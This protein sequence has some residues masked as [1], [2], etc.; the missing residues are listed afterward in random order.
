MRFGSLFLAG[1]AAH[2]VPPTGAKGLNLAA[3]DVK[4]LSTALIEYYQEN[5]SAGIDTYSQRCLRAN[6]EGRALLVVV[7]L[8]DAPLPRLGRVWAEGAGG[9]AGLPDPFPR[10]VHLCGRKLRGPAAGFWKE[11]AYFGK[12]LKGY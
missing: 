11:I 7:H 1:D 6:L 2:I 10:S 12:K 4:Y 3:T 8:A 9:R 5:A